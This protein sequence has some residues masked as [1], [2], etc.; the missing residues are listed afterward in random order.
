ME[1]RQFVNEPVDHPLQGQRADPGVGWRVR[2]VGDF[3][4]E[5]HPHLA[6]QIRDTLQQQP[7]DRILA[8]R[9]GLALVL[10]PVA[11]LDAESAPVQSPKVVR[12]LVKV[13]VR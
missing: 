5:H 9:R 4:R 7:V 10:L 8:R 12:G 6:E 2:E 11:G 1:C 13:S 3:F